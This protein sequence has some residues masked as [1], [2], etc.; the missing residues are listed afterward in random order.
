MPRAKRETGRETGSTR[1]PGEEALIA[2][3]VIQRRSPQKRI[4]LGCLACRWAESREGSDQV[5]VAYGYQIVKCSGLPA[6]TVYPILH[7]L[8]E[9]GAITSAMES[10]NPNFRG[11]NPRRLIHPAESEISRSFLEAAVVPDVCPLSSGRQADTSV[12]QQTHSGGV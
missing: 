3:G 9:G 6:G 12:P 10:I 8:E 5:P 11:R 7:Q 4:V 1:D 2:L